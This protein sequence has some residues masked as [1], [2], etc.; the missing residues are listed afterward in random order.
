MVRAQKCFLFD[1]EATM[2]ERRK[3]K[4]KEKKEGRLRSD[5]GCLFEEDKACNCFKH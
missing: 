1:R 4:K 5:R 3:E 2:T